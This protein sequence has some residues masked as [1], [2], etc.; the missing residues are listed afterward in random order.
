MGWNTWN[1]Y[2]CNINLDIIKTNADKIV[3]LGLDKIGYVYVNIDDCWM[4][5][6]RTK[7]GRIQHDETKF[8]GGMKPVGDYLHS[9]GLKFGLYSSAGTKT[10]QQLAGSLGHEVDDASDFAMVG[11]DYLKYDNCYNGNVPAIDRYTAMATALNATGRQIYYSVCNWGES[12]VWSW[13]NTIANSWRTT[14]DIENN[15]GSMKY[16]FYQN[17]QHPEV[18]GPGGWN[19]PDMLEIGNGNLTISE[20]RS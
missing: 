10:C 17:N 6:D 12:D 19:D 16:N 7:E 20:S 9:K 8:P 11:T 1:K 15:F 4:L 2:G 13:A 14:G 3:A 5:A 18:A